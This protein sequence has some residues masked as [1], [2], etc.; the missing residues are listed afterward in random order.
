[1]NI[2]ELYVQATGHGPFPY[3][4]VFAESQMLP[5]VLAVPTG[6]GKT[7]AVVLGWLWRRRFASSEVREQ[8]PRRLVFCLPMRTLVDQT[9][10]VSRGWLERLG[11]TEEVSVHSLQGGAVDATWDDAPDRD[12]ILIGTQDQLLSRALNRGYAMSRFRWPVHFA[13]LNNDA[14]WVMDEVQLMG[15]GVSTAAQLQGLRESLA[16]ARPAL[17]LWMSATLTEGKLHTVDFKRPLTQL[18]LED[19]DRENG[20]LSRRLNATKTIAPAGT[21]F[22]SK[23]AK[24]LA[25]E[26]IAAHTPRSL[27]LVVVNRVARAQALAMALRKQAS[28]L[29]V[30]LVHGRFR[31]AD[32]KQMELGVLSRSV[33][34]ASE[35]KAPV[36]QTELFDDVGI[37]ETG[38]GSGGGFDGILV[39]TQAVE[40]GVDI[41]ARVLFTELAPWSSLVQRFG[42]CNRSGELAAGQVRWIDVPDDEAAPYEPSDLELAR[43]RLDGL[44][45][46]GPSSLPSFRDNDTPSLPVLRKRDLL[47]LFDTSTDL[48]GH[49]VDISRFVRTSDADKDVQVAWRTW[50]GDGSPPV[51]APAPER[52]ELC[53]V[54]V[55]Q[56]EKLVKA[57]KD[58]ACWRWDS[59]EGA[60]AKVERL[61]P[62]LVIVVPRE[63]GGYDDKLGFTA[64]PKDLPSVLVASGPSPDHDESDVLTQWANRYVTLAEHANDAA[65]E[66]R[67]LGARLGGADPWPLLERA[68]RAHDLGKAHPV[69]QAMLTARLPDD[70]ARRNA[71]PW[72]KSAGGGGG[73]SQRKHFRHELASALARMAQGAEDLE[74]YIIAA[75][76]GKLR[77][78]LRSRPGEKEPPLAATRFALGVWDGDV[79]PETSLGAEVVSPE[80][81]LNLEV[82]EL[83]DGPSGPSWSARMSTLRDD[84]GPF[85]LAYWESLVRVADWR[86]T[87]LHTGAQSLDIENVTPFTQAGHHD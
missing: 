23:S 22:D 17:T 49:D 70:D 76:H 63:F 66:M 60:W 24:A 16:V 5:D 6:T 11:L 65:Q 45:N 54:P 32:R 42:R 13:W 86:A 29:D 8:T 72:A 69:F 7:A 27:T 21:P 57:S 56:A 75:H 71:G 26:V 25:A 31:P 30:R 80:L 73:R 58:K 59:L 3:Q 33:S 83:G 53:R 19:E 15:V 43:R 4:A 2:E 50:D 79:L 9:E 1:M 20:T 36:G 46:V 40:A 84:W 62:G 44:S 61:F 37:D 14:L 35:R 74:V 67:T 87:R 18:N 47:D 38:S 48:A 82:M 78:A 51:D 68:A 41:S 81:V 28:H 85:R 77:L 12:A 39:A 64:D 55:W 34:S 52:H 10:L